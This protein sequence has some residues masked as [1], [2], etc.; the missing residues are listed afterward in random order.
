MGKEEYFI[1]VEKKWCG[2]WGVEIFVLFVERGRI[3]MFL[4]S[5]FCFDRP[6]IHI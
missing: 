2:V 5:V 3:E 4:E 6:F 1:Y